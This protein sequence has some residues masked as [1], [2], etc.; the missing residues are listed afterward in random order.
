MINITFN[1]ESKVK[2]MKLWKINGESSGG[3]AITIHNG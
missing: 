1:F 3:V 2:N